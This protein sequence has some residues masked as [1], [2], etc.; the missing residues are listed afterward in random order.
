MGASCK[1]GAYFDSLTFHISFI[2]IYRLQMNESIK[3]INFAIYLIGL[4]FNKYNLNTLLFSI[5][6]YKH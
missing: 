3:S 6:N 5:F 1:N 4:K 2:N